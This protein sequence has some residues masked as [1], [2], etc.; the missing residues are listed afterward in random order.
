[1]VDTLRLEGSG[2]IIDLY[3]WLTAK[4][5]GTEALAGIVGFGLPPVDNQWFDGSGSG[6]TWRGSRVG[7]RVI[8]IPLKV[9]ASSRSELTS[10]LS[11][12]SVALDPFTPHPGVERGAAR[13][14]FGMADGNE[15]YVDV[16]RSGGGDWARKTDSDDRTYF[17]TTINLEAGD[18]FWTRNLPENFEVRVTPSGNPLLP[19]IARLR[20]SSAAVSGT[21]EVSNVGDTWAWPVMTLKGPATGLTLVGP[22]GEVLDWDG[23]LGI[24]DTLTID[25]RA[26]TVEN[27]LGV[28]L[29]GGLA[30]APRFWYIAPGRSNVQVVVDGMTVDSLLDAQ[31]WPRRWAVL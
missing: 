9:Y 23:L 8:S 2:R 11:D 22:N 20:V 14:F 31:W 4:S 10:L 5:R 6:S 12:L 17:K 28:N 21:R 24:N 18:P 1:M 26:N 19:R 13:L 3:P 7:R 30:S 27:Q 29:Y 15:W 16:V 25:M